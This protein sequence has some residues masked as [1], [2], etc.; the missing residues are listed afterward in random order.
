MAATEIIP[1]LLSFILGIC[2]LYFTAYSKIKRRNRALQEAVLILEDKKQQA[3]ARQIA[4][5]EKN[6]LPSRQQRGFAPAEFNICGEAPVERKKPLPVNI[7]KR[8]CSCDE[9]RRRFVEYFTLLDDFHRKN[10]E[11]FTL[12]FHP[13]MNRF[14][15]SNSVKDETDRNRVILEFNREVQNLFNQLHEELQKVSSETSGIRSFSSDTLDKLLDQLESAVKQ[16]TDDAAEVL[17][18]MATPDLWADKSLAVPLQKA[19]DSVQLILNC[20]NAVRNRMKV[21]LN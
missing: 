8:D 13:I 14:L 21:E 2:V 17:K 10:N 3:L 11:I 20:R 1:L 7:E 18:F 12:Q 15:A 6:E 5:K 16:S 19:E 9:K 4:G